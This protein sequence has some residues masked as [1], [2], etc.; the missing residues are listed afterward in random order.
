MLRLRV[1]PNSPAPI[2]EQIV[3][4]IRRAVAVG[5]ARPGDQIPTVRELASELL[6]NPNT[7]ARAYQMMEQAGALVTRRGAGTF[8]AEPNCA[9]SREERARIFTE[10]IDACLTEAVHLQFDS[11]SVRDRFERAMKRYHWPEA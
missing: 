10:R 2:F 7:I 11:A 6:V 5:R 1:Q 3:Q 4:Q 8:I 9:L